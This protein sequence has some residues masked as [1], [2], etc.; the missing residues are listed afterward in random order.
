MPG[1]ISEMSPDQGCFVQAWSG[2]GVVYP[3]AQGVFGLAPDA[4]RR[5]VTLR[6]QLPQGWDHAS[7]AG[8]RVGTTALDVALERDADGVL[9][10]TVAL[11]EAGW[12]IEILP[13]AGWRLLA[14]SV[15]GQA[16]PAQPGGVALAARCVARLGQA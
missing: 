3:V 11:G 1:A 2:Y 4:A 15:D 6:P 8:V 5:Q 12:R 13:P 9:T 14:L 7:L 10:C 16:A